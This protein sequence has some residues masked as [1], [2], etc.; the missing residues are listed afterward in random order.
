MT[1]RTFCIRRV[2]LSGLLVFAAAAAPAA[3]QS[4]TL[5]VVV[6]GDQEGQVLALIDPVAGKIV[7]KVPVGPDPAGIDVSAD[8]RRIYVSIGND[9]A[10]RVEDADAIAVVDVAA[11]KEVGRIR[12]GNGSEPHEVR[13]VGDKAYFPAAGWKSVGRVDVARNRLDWHVGLGQDGP[14]MMAVS[15][16]QNIMVA[17]NPGSNTVSIVENVLKG[18]GASSVVQVQVAGGGGP[19]GIDISPDDRE[20]WVTNEGG[21]SVTV[22]D[23]AKKAIAERLDLKTTHANRLRFSPDGRR[24]LIIDRHAGELVVVDT[25]TRKLLRKVKMPNAVPAKS[26]NQ[27]MD[28]A[29]QADNARAYVT[30]NGSPG[31]SGIAVVDLKTFEVVGR[32]E[33]G[34]PGDSMA[35]AQPK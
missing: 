28:V 16:S 13:T 35:W 32:I 7:G 5:A 14:H 27:I 9:S 8:G 10:K 31:R 18:P 23:L 2:I 34:A 20:A 29:I 30:V 1:L 12:I 6:R 11:R 15:R 3:A 26:G 24:V 25:A 33:T 19:A 17:G 22:I 4:A 21:G